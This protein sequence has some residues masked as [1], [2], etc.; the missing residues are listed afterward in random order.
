MSNVDATPPDSGEDPPIELNKVLNGICQQCEGDNPEEFVSC[1]F[2][3]VCYH[4][5]GCFD[6]AD[7]DILPNS[8]TKNFHKA[9]NKSGKFAHRPGNFRFVCDPCITKFENTQTCTTND[10]V[11]ILDNR[12]TNLAGDVAV[13]KDLLTKLTSEKKSETPAAGSSGSNSSQVNL[14]EN[15][16]R[17]Q[18]IK[19]LLVV[20]KDVSIQASELEKSVTHNGIQVSGK[21]TNKKGNHVF[22]LPSV[23]A[24]DELKAKLTLSGVTA[25]KITE[26]KQKYPAISIVGISSSYNIENKDDLLN[27]IFRQNPGITELVNQDNSMFEILTIKSIKNNANV[28]QAI[29][30]VS[31]NIR[32]AIKSLG[33]RVFCGMTSCKVYDQLYVKR[34]NK[35][36]DFGHYAKECTGSA[37]CGLCASEA[38]ETK[39]CEHKDKANVN[40]Y[41]CCYNCKKTGQTEQMS[42]HGATSTNCPCYIAQQKKLKASLSYYR[43]SKN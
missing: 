19:S 23:K 33:D 5:N 43:E 39:D 28:K 31:D 37:V 2:C 42:G 13:I 40:D 4:M 8:C 9:I 10:N 30:R 41:L 29:L 17:V 18:E 24:R 20:D 7:H 36:Q 12:V 16:S 21:Y 34:C 38:H 14:W 25:D 22:V 11:Q 15:T 3:K 27:C 32:H 35:C 6:N 1:M 26:P